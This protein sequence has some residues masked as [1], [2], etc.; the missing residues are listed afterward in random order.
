MSDLKRYVSRL[1]AAT[2]VSDLSSC[3][4][5]KGR[6]AKRQKKVLRQIK[7]CLK[8]YDSRNAAG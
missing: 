7:K 1:S 3:Q 6:A 2:L 4:V 8:K 5:Q